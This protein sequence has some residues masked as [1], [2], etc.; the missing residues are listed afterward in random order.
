MNQDKKNNKNVL[1]VQ[2]KLVDKIV[3]RDKA[4]QKTIV[5]KRG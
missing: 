4:T 1:L 2:S 5:E 3:I